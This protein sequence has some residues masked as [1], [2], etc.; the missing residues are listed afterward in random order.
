MRLGKETMLNQKENDDEENALKK[1]EKKSQPA[2]RI[3][4]RTEVAGAR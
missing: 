2:R 1:G 3:R 4:A